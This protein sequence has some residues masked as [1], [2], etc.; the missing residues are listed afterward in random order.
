MAPLPENHAKYTAFP[1]FL[2]ALTLGA[3]AETLDKAPL[4]LANLF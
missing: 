2:Y 3:K 1:I 4:L